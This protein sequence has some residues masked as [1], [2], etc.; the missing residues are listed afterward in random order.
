MQKRQFRIGELAK[1]L[2]VERFVIRFWEKEFSL[3]GTR[4]QGGQR[5]YTQKDLATFSTIKKLLYE[6]G[7]TIQGA[8]KKLKDTD[9][10]LA[11]HKTSF[12]NPQAAPGP[13]LPEIVVEKL[14]NL[15]L[16]L[17]S[18]QK[19]LSD[20]SLEEKNQLVYTKKRQPFFTTT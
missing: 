3:K 17:I 16:S 2:A 19:A 1:I 10:M 14:K 4:S 15:K 11:S 5:F 9:N 20:K 8:R 7:F 12:E 13:H 6:Q 18:L